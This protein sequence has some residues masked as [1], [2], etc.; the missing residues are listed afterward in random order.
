M[1]NIHPREQGEAAQL[2]L[3]NLNTIGRIERGVVEKIEIGRLLDS[4][5]MSVGIQKAQAQPVLYDKGPRGQIDMIGFGVLAA[6]GKVIARLRFG[7]GV[8]RLTEKH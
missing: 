5:R 1:E 7:D 4:Q 2:C 8:M 3:N 6:P